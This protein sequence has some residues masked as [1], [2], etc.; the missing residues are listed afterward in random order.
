MVRKALLV[1]GLCALSS[2]PA[3]AQE[4]DKVELFGGY[5]YMRFHSTN[6]NGWEVAGQYKFLDW[7]GGVADV[8]GHYGSFNG[9]GGIGTSTYTFLFGPQIS[10]P[11]RVSPF[12]HLLLGGAHNS[13][14]GFGISSFSMAVGGGIDAELTRGIHWRLVQMDYVLTQFG[15][16]SQNNFR[17]ST[18]ILLKF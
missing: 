17:F 8:D 2:L 9:I 10:L 7:L 12:G 3:Q 11:S 5:S 14:G 13:T 6:L 15:G 1:F 16:G 4:E 18:G